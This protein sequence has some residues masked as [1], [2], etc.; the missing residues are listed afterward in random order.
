MVMGPPVVFFG[1]ARAG[2]GGILIV[3]FMKFRRGWEDLG[4][5]LGVGRDGTYP[6]RLL[7]VMMKILSQRILV[8]VALQPQILKSNLALDAKS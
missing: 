1:E 6:G 4:L 8:R 5:T 2:Y 3:Q 7:P